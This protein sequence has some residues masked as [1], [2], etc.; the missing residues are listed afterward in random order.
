MENVKCVSSA[1][2]SCHLSGQ[3][4]WVH[5]RLPRRDLE[6]GLDVHIR[7]SDTWALFNNTVPGLSWSG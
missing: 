7:C 3:L 2:G 1:E 6:A 5:S 4:V